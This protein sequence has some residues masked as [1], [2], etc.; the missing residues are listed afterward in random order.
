MEIGLFR[1]HRCHQPPPPVERPPAFFSLACR[2]L[3]PTARATPASSSSAASGKSVAARYIGGL[4][5]GSKPLLSV[6]HL[7]ASGKQLNFLL[8]PLRGPDRK[9][10][11]TRSS[12]E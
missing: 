7:L 10:G 4:A 2:G 5:V 1:D 12:G 8:P 3:Q 9:S 6:F 11:D